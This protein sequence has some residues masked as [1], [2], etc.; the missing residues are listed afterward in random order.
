MSVPKPNPY[1]AVFAAP[2]SSHRER[3]GT[4]YLLDDECEPIS[5]RRAAQR[6]LREEAQ[7]KQKKAAQPLKQRQQK[8]GQV[9]LTKDEWVVRICDELLTALSQARAHRI[10]FKQLKTQYAHQMAL[11]E[12]AVQTLTQKQLIHEERVPAGKNTEH[13]FLKLGAFTK[14][15][16]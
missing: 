6:A 2:P 3:K 4:R 8:T 7:A 5:E 9:H 1:L 14:P 10:R 11:F 12:R 15:R 13:R 16:A